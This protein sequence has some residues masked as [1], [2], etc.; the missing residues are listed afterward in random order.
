M[1]AYSRLRSAHQASTIAGSTR[2]GIAPPL[3][4]GCSWRWPVAVPGAV[5]GALLGLVLFAAP[6]VARF[7]TSFQALFQARPL[8]CPD[9]PWQFSGWS[10]HTPALTRRSSTAP[11]PGAERMRPGLWR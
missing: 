10:G 5:R 11:S 3:P 1:R 2:L 8:P 9:A 4:G 7:L 6:F